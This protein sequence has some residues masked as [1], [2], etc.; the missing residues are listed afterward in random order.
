MAATLGA[1]MNVAA[2][3]LSVGP[4]ADGCR[5]RMGFDVFFCRI[6]YLRVPWQRSAVPGVVVVEGEEVMVNL[7]WRM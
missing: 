3:S 2:S 6:W 4:V 5:I 7:W 1:G